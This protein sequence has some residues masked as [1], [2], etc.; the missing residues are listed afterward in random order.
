MANRIM[1]PGSVF[2][3]IALAFGCMGAVCD[4]RASE[5]PAIPDFTR[6][7]KT[8]DTHDWLLGPTGAHGWIYGRFGQTAESRQIL[9]TSVEAGSPADGILGANDVILGVTGK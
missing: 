6:D 9:I 2:T 5:N 3:C 4:A 1:F 7:G 8:D